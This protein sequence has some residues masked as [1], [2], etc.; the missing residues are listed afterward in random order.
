MIINGEVDIL[1]L[2]LLFDFAIIVVTKKAIQHSQE[3]SA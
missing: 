1:T 2:F 3:N